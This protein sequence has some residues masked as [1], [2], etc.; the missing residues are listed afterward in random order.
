MTDT[1]DV[2]LDAPADDA[3]RLRSTM[4]PLGR[5]LRQVGTERF[6]PTQ[7]SVLGSIT[8]VGP[9]N[10]RELAEREHL[11]APMI[12]KVV[13]ALERAGV[14]ERLPDPSDRRVC[15]VHTTPAGRTWLRA[16]GAQQNVWLASRLAALSDSDRVA[17]HAALPALERLLRDE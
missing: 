16:N 9:L 5:R 3:A 10:L 8:R 4:I 15:L 2:S 12:T 6:T 17:I 11:S 7:L 14:V 1:A 13:D